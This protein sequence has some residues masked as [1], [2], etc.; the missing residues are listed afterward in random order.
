[1]E[2]R[3]KLLESFEAKSNISGR[4]R[5]LRYCRERSQQVANF[6]AKL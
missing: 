6:T 4:S 5:W 3:L 2:P 1:M